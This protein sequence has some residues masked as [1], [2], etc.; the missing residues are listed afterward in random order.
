MNAVIEARTSIALT[1][2]VTRVLGTTPDGGAV[3]SG[4][5]AEGVTVRVVASPR[6]LSRP[7]VPGESW[8]I[9]GTVEEHPRYGQQV[10]ATA[11]GYQLPAGRLLVQYLTNSPDFRGIGAAKAQALWDSLG[12]RLA[13]TLAD[14]NVRALEAVLAP[15]MARRLVEAWQSKLPEAE[16]MSFLDTHGFDLRLAARLARVW[17]DR[18]REM[19]E[20][21][22]YYMLAFAG[23][24]TVD[25][26][27]A[28]LGVRSDDSRRLVGAVESALYDRL[29][30]AHTVTA[31]EM[32]VRLVRR[33]LQGGNAARAIE[34]A[35]AELAV[36]GTVDEGY[37]AT[38][39]ASLERG[40]EG[41]LRAMLAGEAA[42]QTTLF[43]GAALEPDW[44]TRI[45]TVVEREQGFALNVEQR[46]GAV[47]PFEHAFSLLTGGAGVG[48][49]TV[50]RAII[51]LAQAKHLTVVQMALA[52]RAAK[53]MSESTGYAAM[54]IAKF[55]IDSKAGKLG[56][57]G[58]TLVVID[59]ASMLDLP[60]LYRVLRFLPDGA[61]LL[62]V[63]DPAQL[64]P[65]GF[66]L[67][68]HR[69][70]SSSLVPQTHLVQVHR[71]A[72]STGIPAVASAV[73]HH[74]VPDLAAYSG[75][76]PGVSFI[77]CG[78]HEVMQVL[79]R[80]ASD[81]SGEDWQ[82][83]AATKGGRGGIEFIN[84]TFHAS[85]LGDV[86]GPVFVR[87]EPVI[88]L[89]NDLERGLM[90]G[91]L[92]RVVESDDEG[93]S[94]QFE[95]QR[96]DFDWATARD[97]IEHAYAISVHK[98]QGSQFKRIAVVISRSRLLD[99]ALVYTALTRGIEQVVFIGD[100]V[101]LERAISNPP[102][103]HLRQ[104]AFHI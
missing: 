57:D 56:L 6:V 79:E 66:G 36:L 38:G 29:Q 91:T 34:L 9:E 47:M 8:R 73:R 35:H 52:G 58:D 50:L 41:R 92:G 33:K 99:H 2:S 20:L 46:A 103:A 49:T 42:Q 12:D 18:A 27:A 84:K 32:L 104:V 28:K 39:A 44:A 4:A 75:S 51:R 15:S 19:A 87:G 54:T 65:I 1:V 77:Q 80:L 61:R 63:G 95:G 10:I 30:R 97:R 24:L 45:L 71:Q 26:A 102:L 70:V 67:V 72:E 81:W 93:L 100:R 21:N 53:R 62:L 48:K 82:A 22:P 101:A 5:S 55:L 11:C 16:L 37:Q 94:I 31:H 83:L 78:A 7:P 13:P 17:G 76:R 96:H 86:M 64:P 25:A 85:A 90:N 60:T 68:F 3:F 43:E 89:V 40:I 14:G 98:A 23:W 59:E 69:L 88:H 74:E